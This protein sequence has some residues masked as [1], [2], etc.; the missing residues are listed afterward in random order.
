MAHSMQYP[1][2]HFQWGI[3]PERRQKYVKKRA[4]AKI[5][6]TA[7]SSK[8]F[9]GIVLFLLSSRRLGE[10]RPKKCS[11]ISIPFIDWNEPFISE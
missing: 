6:D 1:K 7:I 11:C 10:I 4:L 2:W 9:P 8:L 3:D 5:N